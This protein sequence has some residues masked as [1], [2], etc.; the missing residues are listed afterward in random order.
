MVSSSS[1]ILTSPNNIEASSSM[2]PNLDQNI[3][4]QP[5]KI[6]SPLKKPSKTKIQIK[7]RCNLSPS[8]TVKNHHSYH[9]TAT[10]V[11]RNPNVG[12]QIPKPPLPFSTN[13]IIC[14]SIYNNDKQMHHFHRCHSHILFNTYVRRKIINYKCNIIIYV[15]SKTQ[16]S[17]MSPSTFSNSHKASQ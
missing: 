6:L 10:I 5:P 9:R 1:P 15:T 4:T 7:R 14:H 12:P 13:L 17:Q 2:A 11:T 8:L 16:S 3:I